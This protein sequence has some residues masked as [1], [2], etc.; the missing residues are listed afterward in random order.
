MLSAMK[1]PISCLLCDLPDEDGTSDDTLYLKPVQEDG[2]YTLTCNHGHHTKVVL[3]DEK[4]Q[5]LFEI[6]LNAIVDGYYR[7][8]VASATAALERY[9]EFFVQTACAYLRVDQ[10]ELETAWKAVEKQSERQLGMFMVAHLLLFKKA[11]EILKDRGDV[12]VNFRNRVVHKGEI[13]TESQAIAYCD[14]VL[15]LIYASLDL[16]RASAF[17]AMCAVARR[18]SD[19]RE[20]RI[21]G[22]FRTYMTLRPCIHLVASHQH[23]SPALHDRLTDL[24]NRR[25]DGRS[26]EAPGTVSIVQWLEG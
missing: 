3:Q 21:E 26:I 2:I 24:R 16:L 6:A 10:A 7:E 8:A 9:Y 4:C 14:G 19:K 5:I 1:I 22:E 11:P 12:G 18:N 17:E 13:P 25:Q 20:T 15:K 23:A